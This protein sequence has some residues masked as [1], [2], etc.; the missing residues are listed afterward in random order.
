[1]P[2]HCLRQPAAVGRGH[3]R[4]PPTDTGA[5]TARASAAAPIRSARS[6]CHSPH[7]IIWII[8]HGLLLA[9]RAACTYCPRRHPCRHR[10][11][12]HHH[13]HRLRTAPAPAPAHEPACPVP[14]RPVRERACIMS[15]LVGTTIPNT[16]FALVPYNPDLASSAACGFPISFSLHD[17]FRG[18]KVVIVSL[19][20]AF[21]PVCHGSHVPGYIQVRRPLAHSHR[22]A[23]HRTAPALASAIRCVMP[24]TQQVSCADGVG[25]TSRLRNRRRSRPSAPCIIA[26]AATRPWALLTSDMCAVVCRR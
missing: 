19:P 2:L 5:S 7:F 17:E 25:G 26:A 6:A 24:Q 22:T 15:A 13:P 20:G 23:S 21:T 4:S 9:P 16:S 18:K 12:H 1:M 11:H 8:A 14:S 10:H 3:E